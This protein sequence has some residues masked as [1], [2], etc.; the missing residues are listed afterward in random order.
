MAKFLVAAALTTTVVASVV[1]AQADWETKTDSNST[2]ESRIGFVHEIH[3]H[4]ALVH[5]LKLKWQAR[6]QHAAKVAAAAAAAA[7]AAAPTT[8]VPT[9]SYTSTGGWSDEL[10]AAGFPPSAISTMLYIIDRESGG[11]PTAVYGYGCDG[12]GHAYAGGPACGLTQL[13]PCPSASALDPMVNLSLAFEKYQASGFAP[14]S[15]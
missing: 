5:R 14:W 11:C 15:M 8:S 10:L 12:V 7:E 9:T 3:Q 2:A 1:P 4:E 13:W 6:R